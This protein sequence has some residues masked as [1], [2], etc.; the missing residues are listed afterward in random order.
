MTDMAGL[1]AT[2]NRLSVKDDNALV[3]EIGLRW[4]CIEKDGGNVDDPDLPLSYGIHMGVLDDARVVGGRILARWNK[5]LHQFVCSG[6][7]GDDQEL[8]ASILAALNVSE[9]ALT[10]AVAPALVWLGTPVALAAA[11]APL[12]VRKF[13]IPAKDELCQAWGEA[14]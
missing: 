9:A 4:I 5:E 2:A 10:A 14:L 11:L 7:K 6:V 12:I 1:V 3:I 8:R 13:V